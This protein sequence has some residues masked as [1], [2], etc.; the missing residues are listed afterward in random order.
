MTRVKINRNTETL[1]F[2][3]LAV[4]DVFRYN[5]EFYVKIESPSE[6]QAVRLNPLGYLAFIDRD[7][8]VE[9]YKNVEITVDIKNT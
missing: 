7:S 4:G 5:D 8:E 1:F 3:E 6:R 2:E 9:F